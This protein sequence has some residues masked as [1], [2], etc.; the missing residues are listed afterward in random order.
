MKDQTTMSKPGAETHVGYNGGTSEGQLRGILHQH[1]IWWGNG[2]V[3]PS[4]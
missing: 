1:D 4:G 2:R 3:S